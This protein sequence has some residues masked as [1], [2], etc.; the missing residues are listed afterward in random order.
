MTCPRCNGFVVRE[1][2]LDPLEG[3]VGL[4]NERGSVCQF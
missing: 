3:P 2:L 1:Y 4:V